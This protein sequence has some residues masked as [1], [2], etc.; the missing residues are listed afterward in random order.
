[1]LTKIKIKGFKSLTNAE[2]EYYTHKNIAN[3]NKNVTI[4]H[5]LTNTN[6]LYTFNLVGIIGGNATGKS[7]FLV[8]NIYIYIYIRK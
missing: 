5:K 1:M 3:K 4:T 7:S 6:I 2:I 8:C